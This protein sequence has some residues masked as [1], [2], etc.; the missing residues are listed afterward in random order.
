M[1][2]DPSRATATTKPAERFVAMLLLV[3]VFQVLEVVLAVL[4]LVQFVAHLFRGE[5]LAELRRLGAS[6]AEYARAILRFLCYETEERPFPFQPWSHG[7][8]RADEGPAGAAEP[9]RS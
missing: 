3:V 7:P 2:P 4:V 6:L 1:D 5:P 9:Q 8:R